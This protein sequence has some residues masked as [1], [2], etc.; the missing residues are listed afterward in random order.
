MA[1]EPI[2]TTSP[3]GTRRAGAASP[4][5]A[6]SEYPSGGRGTSPRADYSALDDDTPEMSARRAR[7]LEAAQE[8]QGP[9]LP[10]A[11]VF[12]MGLAIGALLG[13]GVALLTA[14]QSGA[15]TRRL[16][17]RQVSDLTEDAGDVWGDLGAELRHVVNRG[18]RRVRRKANRARWAAADFVER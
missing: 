9:E 4:G 18:R 10:R 2:S 3:A 11:G 6:G 13:A 16:I 8:E 1:Y 12:A 5:A 17:R 14:P 15:T 7:A